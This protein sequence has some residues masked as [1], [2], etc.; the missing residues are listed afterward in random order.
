M[1]T[2]ILSKLSYSHANIG[3]SGLR[4]RSF[5]SRVEHPLLSAFI[6]P[7]KEIMSRYVD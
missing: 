4:L 3:I 2:I 6:K 5:A 1:K 7:L